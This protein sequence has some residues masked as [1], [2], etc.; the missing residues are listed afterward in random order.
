M[1]SLGVGLI[2]CGGMGRSLGRQLVTLPEARLVRLFDPS[3]EAAAAAS[4]E[5]GGVA[6]GSLDELLVDEAVEAVI[7]ASPPG[8][9]CEQATLAASR[10]RHIFVEKPMA[11]STRECDAMTAAAESAGVTLMVGQVL[12]FYPTWWKAISLVRAGVLGRVIG[13][14]VTRISPGW[15][16]WQQPWRR[17]IDGCGGLLM[18]VNAHEIDFLCQIGGDVTRVYAEADHYLDEDECEYPNL[19]FI[20]M[21]FA[22]GAVGMLHTSTVTT[23]A[24]LSGKIQGEEGSLI[25]TDGFGPNG[26]IRWQRRDGEVQ[27]VKV[28]QI[29]KEH[30][31]REELRLF[32]EA[33]RAG[34]PSPIP[35]SEGRRNVAIAL[36]AYESART[37]RP[38]SPTEF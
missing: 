38:V 13:A 20:S 18:E 23:L 37:A 10:G 16:G 8:L 9:H 6:A 34:S 28:N 33:V 15:A 3:P 25:Y 19:Y 2:G 30:P 4:E 1:A 14:T 35:A 11:P 7:I 5:L 24:D 26:V 29:E 31:V 12:R 17:T 27:E 36:A 21:R 22:G 32:V